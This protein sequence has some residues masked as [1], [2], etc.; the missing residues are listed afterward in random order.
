MYP[1]K[2]IMVIIVVASLVIGYAGTVHAV[3]YAGQ[4]EFCGACHV[5][6]P[7]YRTYVGTPHDRANVACHDCHATS[8]I[9]DVEFRGTIEDVTIPF[10]GDELVVTGEPEFRGSTMRMILLYHLDEYEV[11][12]ANIPMA[13][14]LGCHPM[15]AQHANATNCTAC[16]ALHMT[17]EAVSMIED[18]ATC[19]TEPT[20]MVGAHVG[21]TCEGCH[22]RHEYTPNCVKCH[23]PH[24]EER[25][26][27]AD[28]FT[29][30]GD[31]PHYMVEIVPYPDVSRE[32]CAD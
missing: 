30:H 10:I 17:E 24:G 12:P 18:C 2:F 7:Y 26:T 32:A 15:A 6:Q 13:T 21:V 22:I 29:C 20:A 28:C 9:G 25:I 1:K 3:Q 31:D 8:L 27:N 19:H 23:D 14:C 5:M 11:S 16:H 4:P